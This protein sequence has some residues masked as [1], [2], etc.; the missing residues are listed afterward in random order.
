MDAILA[1]RP[2]VHLSLVLETSKYWDL[3]CFDLARDHCKL[4]VIFGM[5]SASQATG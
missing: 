2:W 1:T 3:R 5:E 4:S